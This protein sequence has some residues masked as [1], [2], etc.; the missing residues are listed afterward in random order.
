[1]VITEH[2]RTEACESGYELL[3]DRKAGCFA[4]WLQAHPHAEVIA[5]DYGAGYAD[6]RRGTPDEV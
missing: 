4:A 3:P 5:L 1:M 2:Y 6:G